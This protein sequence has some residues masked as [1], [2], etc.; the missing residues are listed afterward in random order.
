MEPK[1]IAVLMTCHNR[2]DK[3]LASLEA[4]FKQKMPAVFRLEVYLVDDASTD[5]TAE[6]VQQAY[7]EV[8]IIEGNGS[9]FWNGGTSLAF[10]E[11][12]KCDRDYYMWLNDD[13]NLYPE[14]I[15]KLVSTA[16]GIAETEE[17]NAVIV[18]STC[19]AETG[20]LT[21]GGMVRSSRWHPLKFKLVQPSEEPQLC[22]TMNGNCVLIPR[23]VARRVGN[24]DP[25][26]VH[27]IGDIDYGL[28]VRNQGGSVWV[29]PGYVG[30]CQ[31]NPSQGTWEDP[32]LSVSERW[33]KVIQAKGLPIGEWRLFAQRHAG[34]L[35]PFYLALP[36][37]RLGLISVFPALGAKRA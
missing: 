14:A 16:S 33:Q 13:T 11:A 12:L 21:Y 35:W 20:N 27:S 17:L 31:E 26:F 28:R 2:K 32:G 23:F 36:Y 8:K 37:L 5:G 25:N 18:G 30:T 7:P 24:L 22:H 15:E 4:L 10:A 19:D 1:I 34:P 6:A 29:V 9:L 3:T